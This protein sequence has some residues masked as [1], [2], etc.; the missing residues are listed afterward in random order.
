MTTPAALAKRL[1][2]DEELCDLLMAFK[3]NEQLELQIPLRVDIITRVLKL[4][5]AESPSVAELRQQVDNA[6]ADVY[7][8]WNTFGDRLPPVALNHLE[9]AMKILAAILTATKTEGRE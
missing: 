2:N 6:H 5:E 4:A 1:Q 9:S 8:V 3:L 7:F